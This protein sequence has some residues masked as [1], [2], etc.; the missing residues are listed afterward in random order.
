M[1]FVYVITGP[2]YE[3]PMPK[4]PNALLH[5]DHVVPS[6]YWKIVAIGVDN[7]ETSLRTLAFIF[8]QFPFSEDPGDR[9]DEKLRDFI[10]TIDDIES[11][12]G[13]DF[14]PQLTP[15]FESDLESGMGDDM[16]VPN[17]DKKHSITSRSTQRGNCSEDGVHPSNRVIG[18]PGDL[19]VGEAPGPTTSTPNLLLII[20][21]IT[22]LIALII[23]LLKA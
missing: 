1:G 19:S 17:L 3:R 20:S 4:L 14:F 5:P 9:V 2:L 12:S 8:E 16:I 23:I 7:D 11:R 6:G 21:L 13:F 18:F 15:E 22:G 10:V